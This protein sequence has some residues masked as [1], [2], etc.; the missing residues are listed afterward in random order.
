M[1]NGVPIH[2]RII[3]TFVQVIFSCIESLFH[4]IAMIIKPL[5][6]TDI[7]DIIYHTSKRE[8]VRFGTVLRTY[9]ADIQ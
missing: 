9:S 8:V 1:H 6:E 4:V 3:L 5:V 7:H 2:V